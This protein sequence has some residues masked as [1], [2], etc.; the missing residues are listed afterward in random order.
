MAG[1]SDGKHERHLGRAGPRPS[2]RC[3]DL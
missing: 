3:P 1:D 2:C